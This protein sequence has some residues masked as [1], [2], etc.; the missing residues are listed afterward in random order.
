M[1]AEYKKEH[2]YNTRTSKKQGGKNATSYKTRKEWQYRVQNRSTEEYKKEENRKQ[3][4][5][6]KRIEKE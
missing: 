2:Y 1:T 3:E 4:R 6:D 5:N